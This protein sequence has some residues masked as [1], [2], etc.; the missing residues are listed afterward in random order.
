MRHPKANAAMTMFLVD[1][2]MRKERMT[3]A[4]AR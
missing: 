3:Y 4:A 1:D 2:E